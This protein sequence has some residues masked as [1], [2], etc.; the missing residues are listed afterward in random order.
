LRATERAPAYGTTH[1]NNHKGVPV[2]LLRPRNVLV[3]LLLALPLAA[4]A[5]KAGQPAESVTQ[6][7]DPTDFKS[8][9]ETRYE[10]QDLQSGGARQLLVPRYEHAF[11]KAFA[12]RFEV[13]YVVD[14]PPGGDD[15]SGI[16]DI[17]IR[18]A[19]RLYR[20]EGFAVVAAAEITF[21]TASDDR[22]GTG[23][24]VVA[25]L[26][27]ASFDVPKLNSV[28]FPFAQQ[29]VSV[30]GDDDRSDINTSLFRVGVLSRWPN[31]FYTFLEP[32]LYID[33]ERD[34]KTG[35]TLELEVGRLLN[36]Q[37]AIWGRPGVGLWGDNL[38]YIYDWN[39]EIGFRYFL[40]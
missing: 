10:Y 19:L 3:A 29:S 12:L 4:H 26:V 23:K 27:F 17:L 28:V 14:D 32:S 24:N 15:E 2:S 13:P 6:R 38:P 18:P 8:R 9:F 7:L 11:S 39:F 16:G 1:T 22:L 25:P 35:F 31:R 36:R 37:L 20:G 30:S 34:E 33:W 40:D 21:D 5:Q